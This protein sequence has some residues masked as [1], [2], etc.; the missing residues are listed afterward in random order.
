MIY[1]SILEDFNS[2]LVHIPKRTEDF[3]SVINVLLVSSNSIPT[4]TKL[5]SLH[6][7]K[8][9]CGAQLQDMRKWYEF[10]SGED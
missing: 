8:C 3:Q 6:M 10:V 9:L 7:L 2:V 4:T 1:T 5:F